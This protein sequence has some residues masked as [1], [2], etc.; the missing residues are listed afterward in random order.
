MLDLFCLFFKQIFKSSV[1][2]MKKYFSDSLGF[3][4]QGSAQDFII[5]W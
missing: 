5:F 4:F 3:F 2:I 1:K